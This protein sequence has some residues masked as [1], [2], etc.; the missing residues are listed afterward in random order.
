[1]PTRHHHHRIACLIAAV[2]TVTIGACDPVCLM[3]MTPDDD[4]AGLNRPGIW[5]RAFDV[6]GVGALSSVWG[7]GPDDVFIVG[8]QPDQAEI[9]HFDGTAWR[10][11]RV[12]R[13]PLLVWV[14][15]FGPDDVYAVGLEGAAVHFD[16]EK[17]TR[18]DTGTN[19]SLWGVWGAS[20]DDVWIVGEDGID[21]PIILHYDGRSIISVLPP[22][23]DRNASALYKVWGAGGKVFAVGDNGLIIEYQNGRW[24]QVPAGA[25]ADD[26]FVSLWGDGAQPIVAVG[27]RAGGRVG[28]Y[29]GENWTTLKPNGVPGLNGV[30]M[31]D[32]N[33][34]LFGGVRGYI[35]RF[36]LRTL[37]LIHESLDETLDI[38]A[39]WGDGAG[40]YYA[41]GGRFT[42]PFGGLALVRT[43]DA[44]A[45]DPVPPLPADGAECAVA[46]DCDDGNLCTLDRC[47]LGVCTHITAADCGDDQCFTQVCTDGVCTD[48]PTDCDD[49]DPCT[50]DACFEGQCMN[51]PMDCNDNDPCTLDECV[52]GMCVNTPLCGAD[53]VCLT[54]VCQPAP[55]CV[56]DGDCDDAQPCT[57]DTCADG[58]C[59]FTPMVCDDGLPCTSDACVAGTCVFTTIPDCEC[60]HE[61][62]CPVGTN[63][64]AGVC[65]TVSGPDLE[66]GLGASSVQPCNLGPYQRLQDGDELPLCQG[67]QADNL[68]DAFLTLRVKG[69][70]AGASP[71]VTTRLVLADSPCGNG[72]PCDPAFFVCLGGFC[73]PSNEFTVPAPTPTSLGGGV[74]QFVDVN[75]MVI[76]AND[77]SDFS[78]RPA[79][80]FVRVFEGD[81]PANHAELEIPVTLL[82][83]R[84]CAAGVCPS[85]LVCE[86]G[87][88]DHP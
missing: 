77:V 5:T 28:T 12:P 35:G 78:N 46:T 11:M 41:V 8:G 18:L 53:E 49:G 27:G 74:L 3:N 1:M 2:L 60:D 36:D 51:I 73:S 67:F 6:T 81:N 14:Y 62:D 44:P 32:P 10:A 58:G 86:N 37:D 30:F 68:G 76:A 33:L 4:T 22:A 75:I 54:G 34:A 47:E 24:S 72:N 80:L 66:I 26:D 15:G 57:V 87:Y 31:D 69:I 48:I 64:L 79:R 52:N 55:D 38:H 63:C 39:V 84:R 25:N 9:Y 16:G 71:F 42:A 65:T 23:N 40:R 59:V 88:C 43:I 56:V 13:V 20:P 85:G 17:W 19:G 82:G 61:A 70:S 21:R 29:D 50:L 83:R 7:S 45:G